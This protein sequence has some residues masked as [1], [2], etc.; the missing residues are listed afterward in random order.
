MA[1]N[2]MVMGD[3]VVMVM[4]GLRGNKKEEEQRKPTKNPHKNPT[5]RKLP[6]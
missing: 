1:L 4:M 3:G 2:D 5:N 6:N